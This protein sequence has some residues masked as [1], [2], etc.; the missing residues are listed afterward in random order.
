MQGTQWHAEKVLPRDF[1]KLAL[2]FLGHSDADDLLANTIII[3]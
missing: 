2:K 3:H 1:R